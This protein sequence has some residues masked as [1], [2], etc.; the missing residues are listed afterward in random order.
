MKHAYL[1]IIDI[2]RKV[3]ETIS[4]MAF[5]DIDLMQ[6]PHIVHEAFPGQKGQFHQDIFEERAIFGEMLRLG[7]GMDARLADNPGVITDGIEDI[8]MDTNVY[9][10][11]LVSVIRIACQ[12][13][14]SKKVLITDNCRK[15]IAH[16][17]TTVCPKNAIYPEKNQMQIHQETCVHCKACIRNCPYNAIVELVRP[18]AQAC[19]VNAIKV[20]E[21]D[22]ADIDYHKCVS[23]GACI[24]ACPFGAIADKSQ[25]Y[26]LIKS[27][28]SHEHHYAIIAPA[29]TGQFGAK[30]TPEQ[31]AE[32]C[33]RLGFEDVVE[34][35][36]GADLTTMN[37]ANEFLETV[38][39][40]APY[41]ATS[42]CYSWA[43][44]VRK[45]FPDQD[46]Y[47]SVTYPPMIYT[48][49]QLKK[50]HPGCKVTF[51]G[52][53]VSKKLQAL[54]PNVKDH[55]D[56]VITYEELMGMFDAKEIVLEELQTEFKFNDASGTGRGYGVAG[57]VAKAVSDRIHEIDPVREVQVHAADGLKECMNLVWSAKAGHE[58]GKLLEG[59]ACEG[60]CIGGPGTIASLQTSR[61]AND[62]F[63][64]ES[65]FESPA[66]NTRI[67]EEDKPIYKSL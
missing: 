17:C 12:A 21:Y 57:G 10:P 41:M 6:L 35:G 33:L 23:C 39:D 51:I 24:T 34:V 46:Q 37:E 55:I 59:M 31:V 58:D 18:C 2:R 62:I 9:R 53:C 15:C 19:A 30:V 1:D 64:K 47:I 54:Q 42:C 29:F 56:F 40:K 52:P 3:F 13:C 61:H 25:I 60:G 28:A 49:S 20:D 65:P 22:R 43:L 4:R 26:Q 45:N 44:M 48:S 27:L 38:P 66:D 7:L 32:G 16:P 8:D 67:P 11:P 36:L 50:A 14:P 5:E 63:A